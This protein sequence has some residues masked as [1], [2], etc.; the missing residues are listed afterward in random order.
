MD[1]SS[2]KTAEAKKDSFDNTLISSKIRPNL[3]ETDRGKE[4]YDNIFQKFLNNNNL[5]HYSRHTSLGAVFALH[6]NCT[7]RG[8]HKRAVFGK[9]ES[10]WIHVLPI[11]TEQI[12]NRKHSS[13]KIS[14][15]QASFKK[16]KSYV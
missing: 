15:I 11:L 2:K 6:F 7:I 10:I 8:L 16:K 14:S 9:G 1:N 4:F 12:N 5:K 3:N 13:T